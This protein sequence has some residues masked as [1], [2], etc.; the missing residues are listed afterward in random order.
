VGRQFSGDGE[1]AGPG[2][3]VAVGEGELR[4]AV[5]EVE[6]AVGENF[7]TSERVVPGPASS[8]APLSTSAFVPPAK[9]PSAPRR[10][11]PPMTDTSPR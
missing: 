11:P 3:V 10:R 5:A 6:G 4:R 1:G 7:Q 9:R 2:P 8:V